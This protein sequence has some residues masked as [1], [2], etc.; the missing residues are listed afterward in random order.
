MGGSGRGADE[1]RGSGRGCCLILSLLGSKKGSG[2][3]GDRGT[4]GE[5]SGA[6][7]GSGYGQ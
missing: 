4:E 6:R 2:W 1:E 7:K 5:R 3:E